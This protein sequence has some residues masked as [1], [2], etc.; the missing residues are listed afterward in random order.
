MLDR[1]IGL[2]DRTEPR[3]GSG[4]G[5]GLGKGWAA[6]CAGGSAWA[7]PRDSAASQAAHAEAASINIRDGRMHTAGDL[8]RRTEGDGA[9]ASDMVRMQGAQGGAGVID[10][11]LTPHSHP[12]QVKSTRR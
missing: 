11:I 2:V 8:L 12:R 5:S 3:V 10:I 9:P 4:T 7:Y 1:R 6:A